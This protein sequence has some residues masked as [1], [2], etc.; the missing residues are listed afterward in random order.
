MDIEVVAKEIVDS[1]IKVHKELG[2]GL[3]E[4]AYQMCLA[5]ELTKRGLRVTCEVTLPICYDGQDIDSGYRI[6]MLVENCVIIENKVVE[7]ISPVHE[8]QILTYLRLKGCWLGFLLNWNVTKMK[9]G[10]K[11]Y[12]NGPKPTFL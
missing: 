7:M 5:Y 4:S 6:D 1:A 8:A 11:R 10:I 2:P 12:V 3:L 9:Y